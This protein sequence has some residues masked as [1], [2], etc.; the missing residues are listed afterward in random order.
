MRVTRVSPATF[1][2]D[3]VCKVGGCANRTP[4]V[5]QPSGGWPLSM[6]PASSQLGCGLP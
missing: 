4:A 3:Y 1:S 5:L 2:H 6:L